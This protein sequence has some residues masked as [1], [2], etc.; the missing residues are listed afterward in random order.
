MS[1]FNSILAFMAKPPVLPEASPTTVPTAHLPITPPTARKE[2]TEYV[3]LDQLAKIY[4]DQ[5]S[6]ALLAAS[7]PG[8]NKTLETYGITGKN[9]IATFLAQIGHESAQLRY[10]AENLNYSA[11]G[12][13]KIFRKYFPT[14]ALANSYARQPVKIANRV[15]ASRMGNGNEAS[16]DGWK[17]RGRGFLQLTGAYNYGKFATYKKITVDE[18]I[19]ILE[20]D[21]GAW[22]SAGWYWVD[23]GLDRYDDDNDIRQETKLINGGYNGLADRQELFDRAMKVL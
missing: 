7:L 19:K 3:T 22:E 11:A 15:Y 4:K 17:H 23:R 14:L 1:F 21:D 8:L 18:A 6:R 10:R 20:A 9:E 13:Q 16:G 12:L 5:Q 2:M